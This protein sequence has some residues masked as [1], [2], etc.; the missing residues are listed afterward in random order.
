MQTTPR[1]VGI[2][3]SKAH[4]D[5]ASRP[6]GQEFRLPNTPEGIAR[7]SSDSRRCPRP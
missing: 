3:L 5:V 1:F 7:W 4:L 2:D 6:D